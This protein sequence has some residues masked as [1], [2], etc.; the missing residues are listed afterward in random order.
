MNRRKFLSRVAGATGGLAITSTMRAGQIKRVL[1]MFKCHLDI[2]FVD[3]QA[4]VIRKYFEQYYPQAIDIAGKMRQA[5]TDR[6][7][8]TTGSWLLYE[9]LEQAAPP[10]RKRMEQAV[11]GGDIAWH[12]LP[13]NWQTELLD[14]SMIVGALGFSKSLD[15]RFGHTTTGCKMTDVPGHS[16]G[17]IGPLAEHG[18]KFL[19]VGVNS[20]ST[21]PDV[22]PVFLWKD[23]QG[24]SLVVMYHHEYGGVVEIPGSDL[25]I[26][27]EVRNDNSGPH[28]IPEIRKIYADLRKRFPDASVRASNLTEIA[29]AVDPFRKSLPVLTQEI[30]DTWIYGVASDPVKMAHYRELLRL[31]KGW[32]GSGRFKA[33]DA[34]DLAFLR[35]FSLAAEHT[36]GTD[37]KT[38]L[39][40]D[41][42]TPK[43]LSEMLDRPKY[44]TVTN[45]WAEKREDIA[46]GVAAL[47]ANLRTE[48]EQHL[49]TLK[50]A[51]P[52]LS[53]LK[54][55]KAGEII[56]A[57]HFTLALDP[58]T[59]AIHR[60]RGNADGREWAGPE[61]PLALFTY[62]TFSK[63]D[64]DRFLASYITVKTDWAPK[65]FGK[66]GIERFG[67][68]S[69]TWMPRVTGCWSGESAQGHTILAGLEIDDAAAQR[70]G[71][72][73]WADQMSLRIWLPASEPEVH[74]EF[75][76]LGKKANRLPEA[77]WLT[78]RPNAPQT[79]N[80]T[81]DKVD[82]AVSPFDVVRGGNRHMH[83]VM[84]GIRYQDSRGRL[85]ID[86]LDA[87]LVV[88]GE[89]SPI[90]FS[91]E[92]PDL[93]KGIHFS[94][95]NNG[96]GTNYIQWFGENMK[97]R[98]M[99]RLS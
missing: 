14:R 78:F 96:W 62:Q 13:F 4:A 68:Q 55:S 40:F 72:V 6:Y 85:E 18:V 29:N 82:Q 83:G 37:T 61:H 92:Q 44:K 93:S 32:I 7:V 66:P 54:P 75:T 27:I 45:S 70:S 79:R 3:T 21:P 87:P 89:R 90:Y 57:R 30:G 12:A 31:R 34:T 23:P 33:G 28:T 50:A 97:F 35:K 42:Y 77:L 49:A 2:G 51:S 73:A 17:L 52:S 25:A 74:I 80:W 15:R 26:A 95:F 99:L 58:A 63:E 67:A 22:P 46:Q 76:W 60:L 24:A 39:D 71:V 5:G 88:L 48:A 81:L 69:K 41:H 9:Y 91:N 1:I 10:Q 16:R 56:R 11:A 64:Y 47:P 59:G 53:G 19:D 94:L 20:A 43:A 38:W 86:T 84:S 65:D 98:F 8:W 36:W